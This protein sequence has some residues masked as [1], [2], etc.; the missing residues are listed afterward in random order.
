MEASARARRVSERIDTLAAISEEPDRLTRRF[1]TPALREAAEAVA[2]WMEAAGMAARLDAIGNVVGRY[3]G[4]APGAAALL[5]GSHLDTVRDAGRF[6]GMLGVVLGVAAVER[7]AARGE[8]LPFA[9]EVAG[10]ADEE[11]VRYGTAY[12]GSKALAGSF[13]PA[14]LGLLDEDGISMADAIRAAGGDPD[15]IAGCA[16]AAGS[17]LGYCEVHMEQGP[18]LEAEGLPVGVVTAI[19]GQTRAR[20]TLDGEAGH[21]GTVPMG[22]RHDALAGA[23]ALVLEVERVGRETGGLVATVGELAVLP[24]AGNVVPGR[25]LLSL[26]VRHASDEAR[27]A[28][29]ASIRASA[30]GIA[31]ARGLELGWDVLQETGA[32]PTS[33]PLTTLLE[34]AIESGGLPVR[35]LVSGAGHDAAVMAAVTP[36]CMLF[37]RCAGGVSHSPAEE[38]TEADVAVAIEVLDR[39]LHRVAAR[40]G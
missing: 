20:V 6:D 22:L 25:A 35:R 18:V 1:A 19:A 15:G 3:E 9:I 8:R 36:A 21:A 33:Q 30:A 11:G 12:L 4:S 40:P 17:L 10:F 14:Y 2:G 24:G 7:L 38:V 39:F 29:V 23:A 5:I 16:R 26:D 31:A 27:V 32:V 34:T 13:D 37:V 28:A